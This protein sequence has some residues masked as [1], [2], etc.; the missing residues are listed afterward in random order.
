[1]K[2]LKRNWVDQKAL[3]YSPKKKTKKEQDGDRYYI[4]LGHFEKE[5]DRKR[6]E[7][8]ATNNV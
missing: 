2:E 6:L 5:R 7:Y 4:T 1:M 8:H 3:A